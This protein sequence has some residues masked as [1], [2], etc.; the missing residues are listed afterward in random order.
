MNLRSVVV[1][2]VTLAA[3]RAWAQP[4]GEAGAGSGSA[5]PAVPSPEGSAAP[6]A[7]SGAGSASAQGAATN[8]A[9]SADAGASDAQQKLD[10]WDDET[11][12]FDKLKTPDSP[13]FVILGVSPT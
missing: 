5:G 4:G 6:V 7:G 8:Q 10:D 2:V 9:G 12:D 3:V 11:S 13:A 1:V